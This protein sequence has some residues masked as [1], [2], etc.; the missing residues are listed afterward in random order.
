MG[1]QLFEPPD[2]A[3]WELGRGWFSSGGMLARMNFAAQ[4]ASNQ[5][6]N[7]R[8]HRAAGGEDARERCSRSCSIGSRRTTSHATAYNALLDYARAGV[9]L[10]RLAMTQ[11]ATKAAGPRPPDRRLGRLPTRV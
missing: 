3:G 2:V 1:Q 5:K 6:F 11:L 8:D 10:D 4:L 9:R 7:L